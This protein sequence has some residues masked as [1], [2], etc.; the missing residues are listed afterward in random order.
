MLVTDQLLPGAGPGAD[1]AGKPRLSAG[2]H[3]RDDAED[4]ALSQDA[5]KTAGATTPLGAH[6]AELYRTYVGTGEGGRDF[7]GIIQS[8]RK[9]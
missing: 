5:A 7:S 8:L 1:L 6:A 3:R 9:G 4:L 2:L